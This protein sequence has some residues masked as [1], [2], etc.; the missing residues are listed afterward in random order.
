MLFHRIQFFL[1][2][3]QSPT[4]NLFNL[5]KSTPSEHTQFSANGGYNGAI[6]VT[7]I[8]AWRQLGI[9]L[10]KHYERWAVRSKKGMWW[11]N[12]LLWCYIDKPAHF[13]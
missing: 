13:K 6:A 1:D 11:N 8:L 3:N 12:I 5:G 7:L 9:S 10:Q 4:N 2:T